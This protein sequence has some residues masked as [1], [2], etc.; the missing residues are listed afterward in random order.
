MSTDTYSY[1]GNGCLTGD[2]I[3]TYTYNTENQLLSVVGSGVSVSF[4]YD[5]LGR[6]VVKTSGST[7]TRFIYS[8]LQRI[9]DYDLTTH[10]LNR[11][12]F[13]EGVDEPLWVENVSMGSVTY[14]HADETGSIIM[15]SNSSGGI[16]TRLRS[17]RGVKALR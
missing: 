1:N 16:T 10:S 4:K 2:G 11:Y 6:Q 5:P 17:L 15:T 9:A 8:G 14:L 13:G 3:Y 12:V 7:S